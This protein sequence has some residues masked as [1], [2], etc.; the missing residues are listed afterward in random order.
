[1]FGMDES[2]KNFLMTTVEKEYLPGALPYKVENVYL[3]GIIP[4]PKELSLEQI[5]H[6]L[7]PLVEEL[8]MF[9]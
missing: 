7:R 3:F 2:G 1:M 9:W 6:L 5:N 4:G 8:K